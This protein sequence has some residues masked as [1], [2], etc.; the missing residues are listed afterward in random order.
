MS[1]DFPY[2]LDRLRADLATRPEDGAPPPGLSMDP[3]P[4]RIRPA[5]GLLRLARGTRLRLDLGD[6]PLPSDRVLG[7]IARWHGPADAS[8]AARLETAA[9]DG[10]YTVELGRFDRLQRA[11]AQGLFHET[12][13]REPLTRQGTRTGLVLDVSP[14]DGD[15]ALLDLCGLLRPAPGG[16][17]AHGHD[18]AR[19]VRG[20][21]T[22]YTD[23]D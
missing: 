19:L 6:G 11:A 20:R 8:I 15:V 4:T 10:A 18:L 22:G 13:P 7:L 9:E 23:S 5:G 16:P 3:P 21:T 14:G 17:P 12:S 1:P 2:L